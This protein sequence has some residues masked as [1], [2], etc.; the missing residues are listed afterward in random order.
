M[1]RRE[2]SSV[3]LKDIDHTKNHRVNV[4]LIAFININSHSMGACLFP[5][6]EKVIREQANDRGKQKRVFLLPGSP[7]CFLE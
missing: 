6:T 4:T 7:C 1:G 5:N 3:G 2:S